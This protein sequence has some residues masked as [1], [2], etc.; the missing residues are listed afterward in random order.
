MK[1]SF[2]KGKTLDDLDDILVDPESSTNS[3]SQDG[4]FDGRQSGKNS[5]KKDYGFY[6]GEEKNFDLGE[7]MSEF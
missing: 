5:Q 2:K 7:F 6:A 4:L 1:N 3:H